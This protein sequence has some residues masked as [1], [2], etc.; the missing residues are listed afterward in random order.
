MF[1]TPHEKDCEITEP[2]MDMHGNFMA[3][4]SDGVECL[5][6]VVMIERFTTNE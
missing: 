2:V 6:N 5:Y 1:D 3:L 4:D